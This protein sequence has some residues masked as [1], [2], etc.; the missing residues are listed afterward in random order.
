M[1]AKSAVALDGLWG[2]IQPSIVHSSIEWPVSKPQTAQRIGA[3]A[4][5]L[6]GRKGYAATSI[7]EIVQAAGVSRPTLY[8]YYGSKEGIYLDLLSEGERLIEDLLS[9]VDRSKDSPRATIEFL[10]LTLI[11]F[12]RQMHPLIQMLEAN[13]RY[14]T[15]GTPKGHI[16]DLHEGIRRRLY[17]HLEEGRRQGVFSF[18]NADDIAELLRGVMF[19]C[20]PQSCGRSLNHPAAPD[21]KRLLQAVF[22]GIEIRNGGSGIPGG[23]P[24][25][26]KTHRPKR[27]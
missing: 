9:E 14:P 11:R 10:C 3:A 6:F 15:E 13:D 19:V 18:A 17:A 5:D 22:E 27:A 4:L 23:I 1:K 7:R 12:I 20:S 2:S 16:A 25:T 8:Y 21:P 24:H 26:S